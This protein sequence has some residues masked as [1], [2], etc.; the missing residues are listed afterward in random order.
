LK[1]ELKSF[2]KRLALEKTSS[3]AYIEKG[4]MDTDSKG[5]L[6]YSWLKNV[7]GLQ[8]WKKKLHKLENLA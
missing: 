1:L 5:L 4:L 2:V 3:G 8:P 7:T 6:L